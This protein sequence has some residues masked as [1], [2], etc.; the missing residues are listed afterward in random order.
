MGVAHFEKQQ[1]DQCKH[2]IRGEYIQSMRKVLKKS[3]QC[4]VDKENA[5]SLSG[6]CAK[7]K[8][9]L[10]CILGREPEQVGTEC[11]V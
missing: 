7:W 3:L 4:T 11:T 2:L 6:G 8:Y 10:A 5:L 1:G 9:L